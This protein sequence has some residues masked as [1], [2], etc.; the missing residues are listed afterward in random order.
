MFDSGQKKIAWI[1]IGLGIVSLVGNILNIDIGDIFW[2]MVI[3]LIG[4]FFVFR[5]Q[6]VNPA[7][8]KVFFAGDV[9]VD[10]TWDLSK[11]EIRIFAGDIHIDLVNLELP[12]GEMNLRIRAF[13]GK[14]DML[15][16]KGI[17]VSISSEAFVTESKINGEK[18]ENI[19]SGFDYESEGYNEAE[20][21]FNLN[22]RCFVSEIKLRHK[23]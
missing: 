18:M 21:K 1:L 19:F 17:G 10:E 16:P 9:E 7:N 11:E 20:K 5:P 4:L 12:T 6:V 23:Y 13:V 15:V 22:M 14:V 8:A 3:I 2:P